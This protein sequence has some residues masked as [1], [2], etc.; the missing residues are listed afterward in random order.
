[1]FGSKVSKIGLKPP[2]YENVF[3][4]LPIILGSARRGKDFGGGKSFFGYTSIYLPASPQIGT[5]RAT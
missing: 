4:A 1:M 5:L 3:G 2:D